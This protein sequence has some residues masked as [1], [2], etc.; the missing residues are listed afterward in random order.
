MIIGILAVTLGGMMGIW[1]FG[2]KM[3]EISSL[4]RCLDALRKDHTDLY[5]R[6]HYP[7][8]YAEEKKRA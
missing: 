1:W 7:T 5:N 4:R 3:Q 6:V 8:L 2:E